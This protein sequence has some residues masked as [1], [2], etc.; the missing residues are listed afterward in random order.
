MLGVTCN[1]LY[2]QSSWWWE[3]SS[4]MLLPFRPPDEYTH[5]PRS[6]SPSR[7]PAGPAFEPVGPL[8]VATRRDFFSLAMNR[9]AFLV[10]GFNLYH[11]LRDAEGILGQGVKWLDL[12]SLL[13]SYFHV[14]G[15][16]P[17]LRDLR[18]FSALAHHRVT[19]DPA[20]TERHKVYIRAL[21]ARGTR[22][23]LSRFKACKVVCKICRQVFDRYEE[24]E[25]DV[26]LAVGILEAL[27]NP[28]TD[29]VVLVSGDTDLVPALR[30][31]RSGFPVKRLGI[32]FPY[33]RVSEEMKGLCDFYWRLK[34]QNYLTHQFPDPVQLGNGVTISKPS[35][36]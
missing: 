11:S 6:G 19:Q 9:V 29:T 33:R 1:R 35:S 8:R 36:W 7:L 31:A 4:W 25:T 16:R 17:V 12:R 10:D 15:G 32:A 5:E 13:I 23:H 34:P 26:A 28:E 24:K 2:G 14:I 21:E 20:V 3:E 30:T 18:Y 22:V 27:L